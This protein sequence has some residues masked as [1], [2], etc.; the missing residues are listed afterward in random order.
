M[1]Q[2]SDNIKKYRLLR[3]YSQQKVADDISEK[4]ST[5]AEWEQGTEPKTSILMKLAKVFGVTLA[6]FLE[7]TAAADL[8]GGSEPIETDTTLKQEHLFNT[9]THLSHSNENLIK[10]HD[11]IIAANTV[12]AE[13]NRLLAEQ[14]IRERPIV[15][16]VLQ[17]QNETV[18]IVQVLQEQI[19]DLESRMSKKPVNEVRKVFYSKV[20]E[21]KT[22]VEK[23]GNSYQGTVNNMP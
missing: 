11:K 15:A 18:A 20:K 23:T 6:D 5:Y 2:I 17:T 3:G 8:A 14:I 22:Q 12:I 13:T 1:V 21:A 7:G 16:G 9:I 10:Q 4:R 19:I